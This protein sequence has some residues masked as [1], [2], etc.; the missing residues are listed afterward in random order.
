MNVADLQAWLNSHGQIVIVDGIAGPQTRSAISAA[1]ANDC[2]PA[3]T[4]DD[5]SILA[6]RL[7]CSTKQIKAVAKVES[8]GRS[9]DD[10]GRP[11]MLFE[12]HKFHQLTGGK[13]SVT[14]FSNPQG[15][16][17]NED[18]WVK[19]TR[20]ACSDVQA[21]FASASW[22]RFQ[23]LGLHWELL[24]YPSALEMAYSSVTGEAAHYEMLARYVEH[25]ELQGAIGQLSTDPRDNELFARL[26]NGPT[27]KRFSYD[28]KLAA[29]M[30]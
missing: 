21:A 16:G 7:R 8:S 23:V 30:R 15:G 12:R 14:P 20:A 10:L 17:Y 22:G 29:A 6:A 27:F 26:Y 24:K 25:F 28:T 13:Y 2:A 11:K 18:S 3:M 5:I 4:E 19:L 1:F 9:Y